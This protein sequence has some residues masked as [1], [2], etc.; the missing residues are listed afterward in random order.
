MHYAGGIAEE[1]AQCGTGVLAR[2][3]GLQ[4]PAAVLGIAKGYA[5]V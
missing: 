4:S 3:G 2:P 5:D 1:R